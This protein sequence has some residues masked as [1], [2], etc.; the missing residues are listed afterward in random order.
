MPLIPLS[1]NPDHAL[2]ADALD[3]RGW[4][5]KTSLD[6]EKVGKVDDLLVDERGRPLYL[7]VN[8]GLFN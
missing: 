1:R 2:P 7:D 5:V 4:T 6:R 3:V 8:M